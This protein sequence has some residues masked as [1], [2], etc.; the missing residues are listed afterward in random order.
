MCGIYC[1]IVRQPKHERI[2]S[3]QPLRVGVIGVGN[4]GLNHARVYSELAEA[5]LGA[6]AAMILEHI[7]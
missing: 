6:V 3:I 1:A 7:A 5:R 2:I 4:M